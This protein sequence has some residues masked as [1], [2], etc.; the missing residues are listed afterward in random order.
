MI[1]ARYHHNLI[2]ISKYLS[3][4]TYK[5]LKVIPP[6]TCHQSKGL[7]ADYVIIL[8]LEQSETHGFPS[9]IA[10]DR[11]LHLVLSNDDT[12]EHAEERRLFYVAM[13]RA[14]NKVFL[15]AP[16]ENPSIFINEIMRKK[17]G[18]EYKLSSDTQLCTSC[19]SGII[20]KR[21]TKNGFLWVCTNQEECNDKV[22]NCP[23]CSKGAAILK[24]GVFVCLS[25]DK[26]TKKCPQCSTG[27]LIIKNGKHGEFWGCTNYNKSNHC[28]YSVSRKKV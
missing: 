9:N 25:C 14:R 1:L 22:I 27:Y 4:K 2:N 19:E 6:V 28:S 24:N 7:E 12:Y 18:Y 21:K 3:N 11:L 13:T 23:Y 10:D 16:R 8:N 15:L 5:H 26:H 20:F 17:H